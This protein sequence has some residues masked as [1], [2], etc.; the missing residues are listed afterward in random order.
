MMQFGFP[1][2][3]ELGSHLILPL[4]F[5]EEKD[6]NFP[7]SICLFSVFVKSALIWVTFNL[8]CNDLHHCHFKF[9]LMYPHPL[10]SIRFGLCDTLIT[11]IRRKMHLSYASC[12][13]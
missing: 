6:V 10:C 4:L 7:F 13:F 5:E 1:I 12:M 3:I 2:F 9:D 8:L 11:D